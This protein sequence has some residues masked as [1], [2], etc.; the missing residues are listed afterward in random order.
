MVTSCSGLGH[1]RAR[2][3]AQPLPRISQMPPAQ[4]AACGQLR[5]N[6]M[7]FHL[8]RGARWKAGGLR[9]TWR[10]S[11]PRE[12]SGSSPRATGW[13]GRELSLDLFSQ[14][15]S[16]MQA[17]QQFKL[18]WGWQAIAEVLKRLIRRGQL[19][20]CCRPLLAG[21]R[22]LRLYPALRG[23]PSVYLEFSE[24]PDQLQHCTRSSRSRR[25][26]L[27][28]GSLRFLPSKRTLG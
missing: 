8:V 3:W 27:R 1:P 12:R 24:Q 16:W 18:G 13:W 7:R 2:V 20:G 11:T 15:L 25:R 26:S 21:R 14:P 23:E 4:S 6:A 9:G 28:D 19:E 10:A 22:G 17:H 5:C